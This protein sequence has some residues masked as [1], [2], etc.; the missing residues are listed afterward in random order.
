MRG[1]QTGG[2]HEASIWGHRGEWE[3]VGRDEKIATH[4]KHHH[5]NINSVWNVPKILH[6]IFRFIL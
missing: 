4:I 5:S 3:Y 6:V 1:G 2:C